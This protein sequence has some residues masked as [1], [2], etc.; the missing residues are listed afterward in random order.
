M[1]LE[2][3]TKSSITADMAFRKIYPC[4]G[5]Q[6]FAHTC[7]PTL[8]AF[9]ILSSSYGGRQRVEGYTLF[10]RKSI[11]DTSGKGFQR[12]TPKGPRIAAPTRVTTRSQSRSHLHHSS[13]SHPNGKIKLEA[14]WIDVHTLVVL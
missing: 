5:V 1:I 4:R 10:M 3:V 8:N 11:H 12:F 2:C 9:A 7:Q 6:L 13:H 14:P